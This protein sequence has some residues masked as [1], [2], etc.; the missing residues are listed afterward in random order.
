MNRT[1]T[2]NHFG[3]EG[4]LLNIILCGDEVNF[5]SY[6]FPYL[7]LMVKLSSCASV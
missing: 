2:G 6:P 7:K 5:H 3:I 1:P 4:I